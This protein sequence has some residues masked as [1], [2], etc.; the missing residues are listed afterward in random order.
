MTHAGKSIPVWYF[1]PEEAAAD[2][3]V[4]I[5]MHGVNRDAD[6]YRNEWLPHARKYGLLLLVPEFSNAAFPGELHYNLGSTTDDAGKPT[7]R[8][9]WTFEFIEPIFDAAKQ[10]FGNRSSRYSIYGHSA[11]GQ[12]VHRFLYFEPQARVKQAVAANAGWWTVP[13]SAIAFPYGLQNSAI[14]AAAEKAMLARPLTVLLGTADVDTTDKNLRRTPE[15]NAQGPHR[16][17]RGRNFFAA[18]K[19]RAAELGAPFG[20]QLA[21]APGVPHENKGMSAY[22]VRLLFGQP[23]V[24]SRNAERVSILFGG[25]TGTGESYQEQYVREGGVNILVEKGYEHGIGQLSKLLAAADYRVINLETPLTALRDSPLKAKDYLHYSDP[26]ELPKLFAKFGPVAYSLANNHT[27]DQGP[28]G[29]DDTRAALQAADAGWFGGG[30]NLPAAARPLVQKFRVGEQ[31]VTLAVFGTF[32]YR[33]DYDEDYHFYAAAD[34]PGTAAVDVPA[35]QRAIAKLRR[36]APG[37]YVVYFVHWGGNYSWK[38]DEQTKTAAA[39]REAGVDLVMGHGA[40]ALQEVTHDGR[41]WTFFSIGNLLFNTRGRYKD[42]N[43]TPYSLPLVLELAPAAAGPKAT[44]K[45]YPI[46]SDNQLTGYQPRFVTE[47]EAAELEKLLAEKGGWSEEVRV[48]VKRSQDDVG[49][50][51]EF[52]CP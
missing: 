27:L 25:D 37:A 43:A 50:Y 34:K 6:R 40:H 31:D 3:P 29:L 45:A 20:W 30:E 49:A 52:A 9:T 26:V 4:L 23:V 19:R 39:L 22:A 21:T 48:K 35:V 10:A 47:E 51:F 42:H 13:D 2:A 46:L 1:A 15:A 8:E 44:I 24:T 5:V 36:H 38:N 14:D 32:E 11:G 7:P 41:G 28:A 12:F 33:R 17:A 16:F 18:G